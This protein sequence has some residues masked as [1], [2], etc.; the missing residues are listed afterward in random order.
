LLPR[1][2]GRRVALETFLDYTPV[3]AQELYRRGIVNKVVP[4]DQLMAAAE[5][6]ANK[7]AQF[8]PKVIGLYKKLTTRAQGQ[9]DELV[10]MEQMFGGFCRALPG[11]G[12]PSGDWI[13]QLRYPRELLQN[14]D[15][16]K[17]Y[18]HQ[19]HSEVEN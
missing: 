3:N 6:F 18:L 4:R 12:I 14:V 2:A 11:A 1:I 9:V 7:V 10:R 13:E 8:N 5:A 16:T 19:E 17:P 15:L